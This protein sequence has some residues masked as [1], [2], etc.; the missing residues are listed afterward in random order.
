SGRIFR[1][2]HSRLKSFYGEKIL[3]PT[4]PT[5]ELISTI[6]SQNT[7]DRNRDSAFAHL[8]SRFPSWEK[9]VCAP[10]PEVESAIKVAGLAP[11]KAPRIQ[12]A[13]RLIN[14]KYGQFSLPLQLNMEELFEFLLS[15]PGVGP[16][17]VRCVL[18]FSYG[19]PAFPVDTH[20]LRVGRRIGFIGKKESPARAMDRLDGLIPDGLHLSLHLLLIEH[21]RRTCRPR[22]LCQ[23]CPLRDLCSFFQEKTLLASEK[24]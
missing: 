9:V 23:A 7:N 1:E 2:L 24:D 13:L 17:T 19:Y 10:L 11:S 22:P 18:L 4:D 12:E 16:K 5:E 14:E 8:R 15:L 6:L 21:G 3:P 20:I